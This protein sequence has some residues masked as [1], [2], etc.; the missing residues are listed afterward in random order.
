MTSPRQKPSPPTGPSPGGG[1]SADKK[2]P[3][4]ISQ[5]I[6]IAVTAALT[7]VGSY[8]ATQQGQAVQ[9]AVTA[10]RLD[11]LQ[12]TVEELRK[13]FADGMPYRYTT[14]DANR[15]R[16]AMSDLIAAQGVRNNQQ[17][18]QISRNTNDIRELQR[19]VARID[20]RLRIPGKESQ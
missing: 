4:W 5:F 11:R 3:E 16:A 15:D 1:V 2:M 14:Q 19:A 20:E 13:A 10:A 6:P 9:N 17:D 8:Y 7:W 18:E 12:E